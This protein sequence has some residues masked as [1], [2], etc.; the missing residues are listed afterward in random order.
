[1]REL[2]N[3]LLEESI[4]R[5]CPKI[6]VLF[7]APQIPAGMHPFHRNPLDSSGMELESSRMSLDSTGL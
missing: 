1:M 5:W 4:I 7:D 3:A 2:A 6:A